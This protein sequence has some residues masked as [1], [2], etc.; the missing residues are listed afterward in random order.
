VVSV[1]DCCLSFVI[2]RRAVIGLGGRVTRA[3]GFSQAFQLGAQE[4]RHLGELPPPVFD[5][6]QLGGQQL[7]LAGVA[8]GVG[9]AFAAPSALALVTANF[10]EGK[11]RD[12]A[13]AVALLVLAPLFISE[14]ERHRAR[15]DLTG[16]VLSI[17]V[18]TA[19]VYGLLQTASHGW[20]DAVTISM[21][22]IS[23]VLLACSSWSRRGQ[24]SRSSRCGC[25]GTGGGRLR[26][27]IC[28]SSPA[29]WPR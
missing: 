5:L 13:L 16:A 6:L 1:R 25:S 10:K 28:S 21:F 19:L 20:H 11:E 2:P 3:G 22:P 26:I 4:L 15:F 24:S 8:Q 23:A 29:R 7:A 27:S 12:R 14:A 18:M 9:A 17:G